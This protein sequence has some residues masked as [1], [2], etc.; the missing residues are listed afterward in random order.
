MQDGFVCRQFFFSSALLFRNFRDD[1]TRKPVKLASEMFSL[2]LLL[3]HLFFF[4]AHYFL[5][6]NRKK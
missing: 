3:F 1:F 6:R 5:C 2:S 4:N